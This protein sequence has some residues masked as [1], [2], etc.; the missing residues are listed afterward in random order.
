MPYL[1]TSTNLRCVNTEQNFEQAFKQ[2]CSFVEP[3]VLLV[4]TG[5]V[6]NAYEVRTEIINTLK[7]DKDYKELNVFSL[8]KEE[9]ERHTEVGRLINEQISAGKD[10]QRD[11]DHLIVQMLKKIIYSGIEGRCNFIL[12]EFPE[13]I[14]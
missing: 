8:L 2:L 6:Q 3:T 7:Q 11:L 13:T 10:Y 14:K 4:R 9:M 5:G 1:R 12:T